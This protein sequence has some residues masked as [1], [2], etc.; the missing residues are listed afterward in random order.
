MPDVADFVADLLPDSRNFSRC[1]AAFEVDEDRRVPS[2][3]RASDHV[4]SADFLKLSLDALGD[5]IDHVRQRRSGPDRTNKHRSDREDRIFRPAELDEACNAPKQRDQHEIDDQRP[6]R[7]G[8]SRKIWAD[9]DGCPSSR[10]RWPGRRLCIPAVTTTSPGASPP[11]TITSLARN[12]ATSTGFGETVSESVS[13]TQTDGVPF[14]RDNALAGVPC[15]LVLP[16]SRDRPPMNPRRISAR[17]LGQPDADLESSGLWIGLRR[18]F[19][20]PA[21]RHDGRID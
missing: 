14:A 10:T 18:H 1:Y 7:C 16:A 19:A 17:R 20:H 11:D 12:A 6:P 9:H 3:R 21:R 8:P 15:R 13:K 5:L 4:D 2:T